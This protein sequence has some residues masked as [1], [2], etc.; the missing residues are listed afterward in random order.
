MTTTTVQQIR[1][2]EQNV[3]GIEPFQWLPE[4]KQVSDEPVIAK[5]DIEYNQLI[6]TWK[7]FQESI[8][9]TDRV[10]FQQGPQEPADVLRVVKQAVEFW[11]SCKR[12]RLFQ[13]VIE[14]ANVVARTVDSHAVMM[15]V[16]CDSKVYSSL[17]YGVLQSVIKASSKQYRVAEAFLTSLVEINQAVRSS[18]EAV[19]FHQGS[20]VDHC[21]A[22]LYCQIFLFLGE[23][24]NTYIL[25][26]M[27]RLLYSHNEDFLS[28]F[29]SLVQ[30][31]KASARAV[32]RESDG[33]SND[34]PIESKCKHSWLYYEAL[35]E[36]RL[37][38]AGLEGSERKNAG[39][40]VFVR[41]QI[42]DARRHLDKNKQLAAERE[43]IL[44]D[45]V[46]SLP[47]HLPVPDGEVVVQTA[48]WMDE[49]EDDN[50]SQGLEWPPLK[51]SSR[52]RYTK[53]RLQFDS[54]ALQDWFSNDDQIH[55][56]GSD[57][58]L[59][60]D[61]DIA[62]AL[63]DWTRS[64]RSQLI[65]ISSSHA[66]AHP[67]DM[68]LLCSC[69]AWLARQKKIPVISHF[70]SVPQCL[71][72]EGGTAKEEG[73]IALAYSLI[74]QLIELAPPLLNCDSA[75]DLTSDRFGRLDGT[76][77][78]WKE[79]LSV[80]DTLLYFAPPILFCAIDGLDV[81]EDSFTEDHIRSLVQVLVSHTA[82]RLAPSIDQQS[83][84]PQGMLLKVLFTTAG[85]SRS[86]ESSLEEK[87]LLSTDSLRVE[88]VHSP[89]DADTVM[90]DL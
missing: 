14:L 16:L 78:S 50:C 51:S 72:R 7:N 40:S 88:R 1:Q 61:S 23:F 11:G 70:C 85:P 84:N 63:H 53:L 20:N 22:N 28:N 42:W 82:G 2:D 60:V 83:M 36:S 56:F 65:A 81:L 90:V 37:N 58:R 77:A 27:C 31:V 13:D 17:F 80:L 64:L 57:V 68:T 9:S 87:Q 46:S 38:K 4:E 32:V 71:S 69:Y 29:Q 45:L 10:N 15:Q 3:V 21:V 86:L 35:A 24:M 59:S 54:R 8:P 62:L 12:Q 44:A 34:L 25:K 5:L 48:D 26:G 6:V 79:A 39:Q 49:T 43:S 76:V 30:S 41:Q 89:P 55:D 18:V 52:R 66:A 19:E 75:C 67:N 73:L 47:P 33:V 74:R